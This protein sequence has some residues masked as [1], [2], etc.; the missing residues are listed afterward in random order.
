MV[1]TALA[2]RDLTVM[3]VVIAMLVTV[4]AVTVMIVVDNDQFRIR[5]GDMTIAVREPK[6]KRPAKGDRQHHDGPD[7][8]AAVH[9]AS[10]VNRLPDPSHTTRP[11]F[12]PAGTAS[13]MLLALANHR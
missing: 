10:A 11:G 13:V 3:S 9:A 7:P 12:C 8:L 1:V 2:G 4:A 5:P 6:V